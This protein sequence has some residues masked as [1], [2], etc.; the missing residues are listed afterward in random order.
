MLSRFDERAL[1]VTRWAMLGLAALNAGV[2]ALAALAWLVPLPARAIDASAAVE[3]RDGAPAYVFLSRDDKWRLPVALDAVDPR[4]IAALLALEDK[5][6]WRH[7]GVD[8]I[9]IVRAAASDLRHARRVSGGSTLTMQ[10]A[11]LLEPRPRTIR[12]KLVDMFRAVQ[13]DLRLTKREILEAYLSRTPYGGNVEGVE[14]AAWS[15]FGHAAR[16]LTPLEIATLLAVPQ[17]PTRFAPRPGNLARLRAR[18]D[19]ILGKLIA[20]EVFTPAD[21]AAGRADAAAQDPPSRLRRMPREAAHAAIALHRRFKD[22]LRIRSTL[23]AGIQALAEREVALRRDELH[24]KGIF[25]AAIVVVDHTTRDVVAL[26][27]NLDFHDAAHGG[28]IAMFD[29]PRSPGS[30]LKPFVYA[31]AIDRGLALPGYLVPDIPMQYGTYRPRNFD[32]DWAG[33][34]VLRDAL[35]RSLNLPFI[36]LLAQLGV[37]GFVSELAQMGVAAR[38]AAPGQYGLSMIVGGIELTP[39]ELAG[40]YATLAENGEYR[41]LRL[42]VESG[43][44]VASRELG[45]SSRFGP[46]AAW[47]TREAL[48]LRDRPDFPRRRDVAG[49][50]A[51][52]HWKT[53]TSFG[54]RDAWAVGSGPAYTAVVWTGNVDNKPSA[55]LVGSEAAGPLLF[56]VLEGVARRAPAAP[57]APPEGDLTEVEVCAYSGHLAGDACPERVKVKAP[58]H[59]VPTA[60]CPFHQAY[61]VD[62]AT[63]LAVVPACR[64]DDRAY[65]RKTFTILPSAV[66]AWLTG[67]QR[68]VPT[69]PVFDPACAEAAASAPPAIVTPGEGQV[70]TLIPGVD[71]AHQLVPLT[72]ATRAA[73][74]TWFVDGAFVATAGS[75]ERVYWT[76]RAGRHA[77]VV[78][79]DA[80][81]KARR[82]L[83]VQLAA[84]QRGAPR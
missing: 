82:T 4:F 5:R 16:S 47:L 55:E 30:T 20:A 81:R 17:G 29:R 69:P 61:D 50:P 53:G 63:G 64:R 49:V 7:A 39:L 1:R 59:A 6:F 71:P 70:I 9:A 27:G 75:D 46:A 83:D 79:D 78:A 41:P 44:R 24:R 57:A 14:S 18:R 13:L 72:A 26:V 28:Q 68:A 25:G 32:G 48:A 15:Y 84:A 43:P 31:L 52:I 66:A 60:P 37:E 42:L 12:S 62:R 22:Q 21:A 3:Y 40:L 35:S 23:D 10:L 56:D 8:P 33:L 51:Q 77:I 80:G 73:R 65:D 76:P 11:R 38:R 36:D 19:D 2:L 58:I 34:V 74:V 45:G 67:R 54:F